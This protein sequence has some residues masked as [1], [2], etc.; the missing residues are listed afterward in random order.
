MKSSGKI[1]IRLSLCFVIG[2]VLQYAV[3]AGF[4]VVG[5][6]SV[7]N[8]DGC[9]IASPGTRHVITVLRG[10]AIGLQCLQ[11]TAFEAQDRWTFS[12]GTE[13]WY[14]SDP[15]SPSVADNLPSWSRISGINS[16]D[17]YRKLSAKRLPWLE[18]GCGWP[19][20]S[21]TYECHPVFVPGKEAYAI[22]VQHGRLISSPDRELTLTNPPR[23]I[24][25]GL[26]WPGTVANSALF[27]GLLALFWFFTGSACMRCRAARGRCLKCGYDLCG[28]VSGVCPECGNV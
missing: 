13:E 20:I 6:D 10:H 11:E 24:P 18:V 21:A 25:L 14:V 7:P 26:Y 17:W 8:G 2:A 19:W 1:A 12:G 15:S 23:A 9:F 4:G 28:T 3:A 16:N 5:H 22:E 27:G